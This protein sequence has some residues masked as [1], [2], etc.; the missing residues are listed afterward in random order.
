[1]TD[2]EP[3]SQSTALLHYLASFLSDHKRDLLP[4]LLLNRT[5]H[6]SV[7]LEDIH[8]PHNASACLRSCDCFGVQDVHIIENYNEYKVADSIAL[9][10][11]QW[12][13]TRQYNAEGG[14][15]TEACLQALRDDGYSIV[16]TSPHKAD[17]D[18]ESFDV[19]QK[20]ALVFGNEKSGASSVVREMSD[21][22]MRV[23]IHGFTESFN[24][25]VAVAVVLHHLVWRMRELDLNW[26][27]TTAERDELLSEWVWTASNKRAEKL[28]ERFLSEVW[29]SEEELA[30]IE[31]W[32]DW[33]TVSP[34]VPLE[35]RSRSWSLE[36]DDEDSM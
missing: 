22:V 36:S 31:A 14:K 10:A 5:R 16:M 23:P 17:C 13:T 33:P 29:N 3:R 2:N 35:R 24:I 21:H 20:T 34:S 28:R 26:K 6:L 4:R 1:M 7:V 32:P 11:S 12:L 19:N 8:K 15:N 18:L 9:G 25:S 30:Q 27:L